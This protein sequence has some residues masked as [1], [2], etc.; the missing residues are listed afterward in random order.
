MPNAL[1]IVEDLNRAADVIEERGW[2]RGVDSNGAGH[3]CMAGAVGTVAPPRWRQL[4]C[5]DALLQELGTRTVI[6]WNDRQRDRRKVTRALRR[7]ARKVLGGQ[8][9]VDV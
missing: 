2:C 8:I 4:A 6:E 7:T 3:V 5:R 9:K 1:Q